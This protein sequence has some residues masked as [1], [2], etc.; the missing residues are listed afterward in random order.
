MVQTNL[1][2]RSLFARVFLSPNQRRLRAGWRIVCHLLMAIVLFVAISLL[3]QPL[4]SAQI[5]LSGIPI[6]QFLEFLVI[7]VSIFIARIWFDRRSV[8]SLGL[9]VDRCV[10]VDLVFGF[11]LTGLSIALMYLV[12]LA[13]GWLQP[14]PFSQP[15][16]AL[17]GIA[18]SLLM[19]FLGFVF[20]GWT[21][22]LL[23]RG[24][25]LQ[26]MKE[27]LNL[28]WAVV[29][30]S[31]IFGILHLANQNATIA[32]A[33]GSAA[34]GFLLAYAYLRTQQLWLPIGMHIGWNFFEGNV[35]G[36]PV[37]GMKSFRLIQTIITGPEAITGG[38]FGPEAGLIVLPFLLLMAVPIYFY[39]RGRAKAISP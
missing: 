27:G 19:G 35:F 38:A 25:W 26:N 10:T 34:A 28:F 2:K 37:S 21:E 1:E 13:A 20:I 17:A 33:I 12:M 31:S 5:G 36:F 22:E 39:T 23:F 24:Y 16:M 6:F 32:G 4:S 15:D 8:A 11:L 7:T 9:A 14:D 3:L 18:G 29:I 30:P